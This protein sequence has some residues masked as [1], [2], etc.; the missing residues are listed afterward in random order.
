MTFP[1]SAVRA[2]WGV[3]LMFFT[4]GLL[5]ANLLPRY[6]EVKAAYALSDAAFGLLVIAM[7]LGAMAAAAL[8]GP[9]VR[10]YGPRTVTAVGTALI[11]GALVLAVQSPTVLV[12]ALFL[13][14]V[15]FADAIVD[16]AQNVQGVAV[17][18]WVGRSVINSLH[19]IWSLGAALGGVVGTASAAAELPLTT[20]LAVTGV[21]VTM[22]AVVASLAAAVPEH[23]AHGVAED[24]EE[25]APQN[26]GAPTS[27]ARPWRFLLPIGLLGIC[28]TLFEEVANSWSALFIGRETDAPAHLAGLGFTVVLASQF[29]GRLAG[30]PMTDRWG[31]AS[32]ARFGSLVIALGVLVMVASSAYPLVMV[33]LA[34]MGFGCATLVPAAFAA[35][36]RIPGL[37]H[38][39]GIAIIGWMIRLG[40]LITSPL[41][42]V[43]SQMSSLRV[44]LLV[45]LAAAVL[46]AVLSHGLAR[47][48][49]VLQA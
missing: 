31:R 36:A 2:R 47:R 26:A 9:A 23:L 12:F 46:A 37:K 3:S 11:A 8:A 21:V 1:L 43:I 7:P 14:V 22:L 19:A 5:V 27:G 15:G 39:T 6:P 24:S 30:D 32:V 41:I 42:G 29:I 34:L 17:E 16:A 20:Q 44:A 49:A 38:G 28:G 25:G 48:R 33:G 35:A 45:P 4:N 13:A 10:R 40:F 18:E